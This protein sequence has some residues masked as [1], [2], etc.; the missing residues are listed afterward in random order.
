MNRTTAIRAVCDELNRAYSK[1]PE[2]PRN[3]F[4]GLA[5]ISQELGEAYQAALRAAFVGGDHEAVSKEVVQVA[6][7]ALRFLCNLDGDEDYGV[8]ASQRP[9]GVLAPVPRDHTIGDCQCVSQP[10]D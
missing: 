1:H 10:S 7:M 2:W 3:V 9:D 4:M 8:G 5:I 6:A